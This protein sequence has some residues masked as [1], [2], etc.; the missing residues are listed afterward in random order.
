M[1]NEN[2]GQENIGETFEKQMEMDNENIRETGTFEKQDE[3]GQQR[4]GQPCMDG[5]AISIW[6][7]SMRHWLVRPYTIPA[8]TVST[9]GWSN[10]AYGHHIGRCPQEAPTH[11]AVNADDGSRWIIP[12]R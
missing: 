11:T 10:H 4:V 9:V 5:M 7:V 2:I 6:V 12:R 8:R 1:D 3:N